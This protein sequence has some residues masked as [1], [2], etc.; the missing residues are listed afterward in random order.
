MSLAWQFL[1]EAWMALT[2]GMP[3]LVLIAEFTGDT[4]EEVNEKA[5]LLQREVEGN[6]HI[7]TRICR[8]EAEVQKYWTIRRESFALLR[9]HVHGKHT[10]PFIDDIAVLP[11]KMPQ[12]LPELNKILDKYKNKMVYTLAGH[13]G[14]GNF[15]IIPLID[16]SDENKWFIP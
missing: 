16:L 14:N 6:F 4:Q 2:G 1:P 3:K 11:E 13:I 8:S 15:H 12:F 9:Q 10:A 5:S 7:K